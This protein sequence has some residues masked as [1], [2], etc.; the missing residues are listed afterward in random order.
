M[1]FRFNRSEKFLLSAWAAV[2]GLGLLLGLWV[3]SGGPPPKPDPVYA[4]LPVLS[5][6]VVELIKEAEP[7]AAPRNLSLV[8]ETPFGPLPRIA[9]DGQEP[10]QAYAASTPDTAQKPMI[11]IIFTALG[12]R[13]SATQAVIEDMPAA[14]TL[15]FSPYGQNLEDWGERAR[16]AGHEVLLMVPMEPLRYPANNPGPDTLLSNAPAAEN[17]KRF[18]RILSKMQGYVGVMNDMGSAFTADEGAMQ[19]ILADI[20]DRGLMFVDA[21][22]THLSIAAPLAKELALPIAY[23]NR[24]IDQ[25]PTEAAIKEMLAALERT[26]ERRGAAVGLARALP[27]SQ[28]VIKEWATN[29][30]QED[31]FQLV[32]VSAI[33]NRQP[34]R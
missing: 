23:N 10:W 13:Q 33:A 4:P 17:I 32:P 3:I 27:I 28:S 12:I 5:I 20:K 7:S 31:Q 22:S 2:L 6:P 26:A 21:R 29:M 16:V 9:D 24:F 19:P 25:N 11:A 15:A 30:Q 18:Y 14:I 8:E 1:A 34:I